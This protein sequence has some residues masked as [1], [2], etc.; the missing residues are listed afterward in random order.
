MFFNFISLKILVNISVELPKFV[1]IY[2]FFVFAFS[3]PKKTSFRTYKYCIKLRF[4]F[5]K[6]LGGKSQEP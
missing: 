5:F 4:A 6:W 1:N 2:S 3:F